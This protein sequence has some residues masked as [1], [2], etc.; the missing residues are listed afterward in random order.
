M[1][2]LLMSFPRARIVLLCD[3]KCVSWLL[4]IMSVTPKDKRSIMARLS[5]CRGMS[6]FLFLPH[7]AACGIFVP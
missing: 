7:C 4:S 6:G 5:I 3:V 1:K 2:V